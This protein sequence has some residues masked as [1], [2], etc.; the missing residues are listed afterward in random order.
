MFLGFVKDGK[1]VILWSSEVI[2]IVRPVNCP[3]PVGSADRRSLFDG[4]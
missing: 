2:Y 4:E 1:L 3:P